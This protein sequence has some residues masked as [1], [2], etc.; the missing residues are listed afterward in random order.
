M[1]AHLNMN[2]REN[3]GM[4]VRPSLRGQSCGRVHRQSAIRARLRYGT[5]THTKH[6]GFIVQNN[7]RFVCVCV[8]VPCAHLPTRT[9]RNAR[10]P[11]YILTK[12]VITNSETPCDLDDAHSAFCESS[13]G[14]IAVAR[15]PSLFTLGFRERVRCC[16]E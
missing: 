3:D 13:F 15:F 7:R 12:W 4:M 6:S 14:G 1:C 8:Q 9:P 10:R 11:P 2:A 16:R 5:H